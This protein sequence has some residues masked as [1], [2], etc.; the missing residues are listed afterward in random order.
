MKKFLF[1]LLVIC[2]FVFA[3]S[4]KQ[5]TVPAEPPEPV[6]TVTL[7]IVLTQTV[8]DT[9]IPTH[10]EIVTASL[11]ATDTEITTPTFTATQTVTPTFTPVHYKYS[12]DT[13]LQGWEMGAPLSVANPASLGFTWAGHNTELSNVYAGT[14]SYAI[15]VNMTTVTASKRGDVSRD[16]SSSPIDVTGRTLVVRV[17]IPAG[18]EQVNPP[19]CF[20]A[21]VATSS[22][23]AFSINMTITASGWQE[24]L[25]PVPVALWTDSVEYVGIRMR[26]TNGTTTPDWAGRIYLDEIEW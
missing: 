23:A 19:Y 24:Y 6:F 26:K 20:Q 8:V 21:F 15:D 5:K 17:K 7:T 22:S 3:Y 13:D 25:I 14:G 1:F 18:L 11:T 9:L 16:F 4:C 2:V 12:F 10:T